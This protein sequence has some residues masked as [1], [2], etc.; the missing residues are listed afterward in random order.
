MLYTA[1]A[2]DCELIADGIARLPL[3]LHTAVV[4][5]SRSKYSGLLR[6]SQPFFRGFQL[7]VQLGQFILEIL[8]LGSAETQRRSITSAKRAYRLSTFF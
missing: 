5:L 1:S 4:L 3:F 8:E 2:D 6:A 7:R